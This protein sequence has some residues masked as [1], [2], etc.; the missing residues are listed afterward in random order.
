M[1]KQNLK[2]GTAVSVDWLDSKAIGGWSYSPLRV[3]EPGFVRS[4]GYVIQASKHALTL[5]TS[6]DRNGA[7]MDDLSIPW[8]CI[9]ELEALPDDFSRNGPEPPEED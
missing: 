8:G 1:K 6:I 9:S 2:F 5:S 4:L 7:S 3:R